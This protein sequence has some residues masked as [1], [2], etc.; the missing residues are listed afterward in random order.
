MHD[1]LRCLSSRILFRSSHTNPFVV[2]RVVQS[3]PS[4]TQGPLVSHL[5][6]IAE[7]AQSIQRVFETRSQ[8]ITTHLV[9]LLMRE[10]MSEEVNSASPFSFSIPSDV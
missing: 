5:A 7:F 8:V 9:Q 4:A 2:Q 3:L 10:G 6:A 1:G